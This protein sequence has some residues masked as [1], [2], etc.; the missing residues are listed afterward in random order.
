MPEDD[1]AMGMLDTIESSQRGGVRVVRHEKNK[2][3][4]VTKPEFVIMRFAPAPAITNRRNYIK[5]L[6][7]GEG[8]RWV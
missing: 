3:I 6:L 7:L 2:G 4:A 8:P 1:L 5:G